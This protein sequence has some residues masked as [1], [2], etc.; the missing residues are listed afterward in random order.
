MWT[1]G[2]GAVPFSR[3]PSG[4]CSRN[5]NLNVMT[6]IV[7]YSD[8]CDVS[9]QQ[10]CVHRLTVALFVFDGGR[11]AH[12]PLRYLYLYIYIPQTSILYVGLCQMVLS[13]SLKLVK[14]AMK[15]SQKNQ[16]YLQVMV[17]ELEAEVMKL[18]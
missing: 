10:G 15:P 13:L 8:L 9:L 12:T 7:H 18:S 17:G 6:L 5:R 3:P 2:L 11:D 16:F 4:F 1:V 14:V